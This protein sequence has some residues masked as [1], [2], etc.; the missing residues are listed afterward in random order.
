MKKIIDTIEK[1]DGKLTVWHSDTLIGI[2]P[3]EMMFEA[4]LELL[5]S[6]MALPGVPFRNGSGAVWIE[7]SQRQVMTAQVYEYI[8]DRKEGW[9]MMGSTAPEFRNQ[10]LNQLCHKYL[11][12]TIK[13][14]GGL[15]LGSTISVKNEKMLAAA[16]KKGLN[17]E[18]YRTIQWL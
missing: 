15:S 12:Q 3:L 1:D 8:E 13:N 14:R 5:K 2:P 16:V 18:F 9:I 6:G 7:N 17:P 10:G 4:Y 11:V